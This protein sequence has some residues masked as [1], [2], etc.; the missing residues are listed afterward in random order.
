MIKMPGTDGSVAA[1]VGKQLIPKMYKVRQKFDDSKIHDIEGEVKRSLQRQGTLDRVRGGQSIAITAGSRGIAN[2]DKIIKAV[3]DEVKRIGGD[4]FIVPAMGSHGGATA[5]GQSEVLK[6]LG[7]SEETMGCMIRSS[8]E[9]V[10]IG[11]SEYG[12]PVRIDKNALGADGI[13]VV[14]RLKPHT[15]FR[16]RYESGLVKMV[17][18]GLGK[19]F[20]A[21]IC[22]AD[23]FKYMEQNVTSIAKV[24]LE[25]C[26]ILFG[27]AIIENSFD[28][29]K[30]IKAV[31]ADKF[32]EE[33]PALLEESKRNMPSIM[34]DEIDVLI[35]DEMGKN[36]SGTGMDPNIT[37]SFSTPYVSGGVKKQ[38]VVVLDLTEESH[39][40]GVGLGL[41]DFSVQRLFDKVDLEKVYANS[42]TSTVL[43]GAKIPVIL[44]NDQLAIQ[45]AIRTCNGI[46]YNNP[47]IV[48]I[49]NTLKLGEIYISESLLEVARKNPQMEVLEGPEILGFNE[50]GNLF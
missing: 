15:A 16:G 18:I 8:M 6:S 32:F 40:N 19:Q 45:A 50:H 14:G 4:P 33:E 23:S 35:V 5:E 41:A 28:E 47:R 34:F 3:V 26:K 27:V 38:R 10:Q 36:I 20:G 22:H 11:V 17:T 24:A 30:T 2:I 1:I 43:T 13:I 21:E 25:N 44:A 31:P 7:I 29:T 12:K 37:G 48:R 9:T 42:F 46:D 39:G 49:Q